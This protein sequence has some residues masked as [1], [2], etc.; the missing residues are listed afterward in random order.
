MESYK[1]FYAKHVLHQWLSAAN[2]KFFSMTWNGNR[3]Y[4]EY[5]L[6]VQDSKPLCGIDNKPWDESPAWFCN[7]KLHYDNHLLSS[8]SNKCRHFQNIIPSREDLVL[9]GL[10]VGAILDVAIIDDG[11]V[12]YGF[13]IC[14]TSPVMALKATLL[15][16]MTDAIIYEVHADYILN[17]IAKPRVWRGV[18]LSENSKV[19]KRWKRKKRR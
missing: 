18:K 10:K 1:H 3:I 11:K 7:C 14:H 2:G 9:K 16:K 15:L 5:P 8:C 6:L 13:E 12:K 17:Q 4:Q 19:L